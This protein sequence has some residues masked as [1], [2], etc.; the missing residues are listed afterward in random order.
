VN[1]QREWLAGLVLAGV[2]VLMAFG[3]IEVGVRTLH[4]VPD[5]FWEPDPVRG[6][7]LIAGRAGWWTQEEREFVVPVQINALGLRDAERAYAKPAGVFRILVLGDSFVEAM[8][9]RLEETF[10]RLLESRLRTATGDTRVEVISAGVSG[11]GTASEVLYF[12]HE[13]KRFAPDLV[14]LAF[15][16]GNDVKNNSPTLE[17]KL[18]PVYVDGRLARVTGDG[19]AGQRRGVLG[20]SA[21]YQYV[22][23]VVL[24]RQPTLAQ[25]LVR[26]GLLQPDAVR[27][28][29]DRAGVP[30]DYWVY[31][32][33]ADAEWTEAWT[34]T[35]RLL[36]RLRQSVAATGAR[37][38]I[39]VLSAREQ[40]Y[41]TSW[42]DVLAAHPAMAPLPWDLDAPQRRVE[43]WCAQHQVPCVPL[44]GA[45]REAV[46]AGA[47]PLHFH[48][49]GHFTPA[50]HQLAARVLAESLAAQGVGPP[51]QRGVQR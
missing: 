27:R 31:A 19:R 48:H 25:A 28:T 10:P 47:A 34:H 37:F 43:T 24:T 38:A 9:V 40:V 8:H 5:R 42:Q 32:P 45:F 35:E 33:T 44:A 21:A 29:P 46:Q 16:P 18:R 11:Y 14:V 36:D 23:Q 3:A 41:P 30:V 17:D 20:R 51:V 39:V 7:R 6:A 49:D 22:R 13:G 26:L 4:L 15:Y 2:S 1:R 12:E 50:G